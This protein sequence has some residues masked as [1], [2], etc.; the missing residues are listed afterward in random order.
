[1]TKQY[2]SLSK[3]K[4]NKSDE[5]QLEFF[6]MVLIVKLT[7]LT[8][9]NF[10]KW[11]KMGDNQYFTEFGIFD[12][13]LWENHFVLINR[14]NNIKYELNQ[15]NPYLDNL[16]STLKELNNEPLSNCLQILLDNEIKILY[17]MT[18]T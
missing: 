2:E 18:N 15:T 1:M 7:E 8:K 12:I 10:I 14:L 17:G 6:V 11:T 3:N 4:N 13:S 5:S 16:K 9:L